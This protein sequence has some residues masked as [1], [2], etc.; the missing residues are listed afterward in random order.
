[1]LG[2]RDTECRHSWSGGALLTNM[3][4]VNY[5]GA[6]LTDCLSVRAI[7]QQCVELKQYF[8][9]IKEDDVVTEWIIKSIPHT[10]F[11]LN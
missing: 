3:Q 8:E 10:H 9:H 4:G 11:T 1:M 5:N 7:E 6:L 2:F